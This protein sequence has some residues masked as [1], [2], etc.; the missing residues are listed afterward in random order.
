[1]DI[2]N[3]LEVFAAVDACAVAALKAC[4]DGKLGLLDLRHILEPAK[5]A[6]AAVRDAKLVGAELKDVDAAE[7]E[8]LLTRSTASALKAVEAFAALSAVLAVK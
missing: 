5:A 4:E 7:L 8:V 3:T 6:A 2:K 1:M